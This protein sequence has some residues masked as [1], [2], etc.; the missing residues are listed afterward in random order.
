M[1]LTSTTINL[2]AKWNEEWSDRIVKAEV[3]VLNAAQETMGV[4]I[5]QPRWILLLPHIVDQYGDILSQDLKVQWAVSLT[6]ASASPHIFSRS[7]AEVLGVIEKL[8]QTI[9]DQ[10][11]EILQDLLVARSPLVEEAKAGPEDFG[12][13]QA[14]LDAR[15]ALLR[16]RVAVG[17]APQGPEIGM[18]M[19]SLLGWSGTDEAAAAHGAAEVL[20]EKGWD[21][22]SLIFGL[23]QQLHLPQ[24]KFMVVSSA[25]RT[26]IRCWAGMHDTLRGQLCDALDSLGDS[27]HPHTLQSIL[28]EA[29]D[30]WEI[31][32]GI[33][34]PR[35][36]DLAQ[37]L[38]DH[39]HRYVRDW[40]S[41]VLDVAASS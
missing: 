23:L 20:V 22:S 3:A 28:A 27:G 18:V 7:K 8:A 12:F 39:R 41:R 21:A 34:K 32:D 11:R 5:G 31:L 26:L 24:K 6:G 19:T 16:A 33:A 17:I 29:T 40:A 1:D 38:A 36:A 13:S 15:F 4:T 35:I 37:R 9:G 25:A 14:C 10:G 30:S 2:N